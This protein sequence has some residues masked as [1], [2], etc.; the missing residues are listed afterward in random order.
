M[1]SATTNPRPADPQV[2]PSAQPSWRRAIQVIFG[3]R[4][5]AIAAVLVGIVLLTTVKRPSFL[6]SHDGWRDLLLSPSILLLLAIGQMV[7]IVTR[8]VDLSVGSTLGITAYLSGQL[9]IAN[10]DLPFPVVFVA[11]L[12][13]GGLLGA[14]NGFLVTTFRVPALVITLGTMYIFRG[15]LK[16]FAG[17]SRVNA[18]DF[19]SPF[20]RLGTAQLVSLPVLTLIGLV[21]LAL[22]G[23]Y[24][25][26][27]RGGRELYAIGSDPAAAVLYGLPTTRRV[28]GAFVL[29]GALAG[30]AGVVTAAR[31]AT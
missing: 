18:G 11:G 13:V 10:P 31:Y 15:A 25:Q 14:V 6:F 30:L 22:V 21:V 2:A 17:A 24:L 3:S 5:F 27:A 29:C 12:I 19:P 23:Y 28:F 7:V 1:S 8:N 9:F 16:N 26:T 20:E 4:E